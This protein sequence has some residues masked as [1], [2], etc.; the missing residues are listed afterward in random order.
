MIQ[1]KIISNNIK[2]SAISQAVV[3]IITFFLFP[4]IVSHVGKEVYGAY[5]LVMT[6]T[7]YLGVLDFGVGPA[8]VKYVAEFTGRGDNRGAK[9]IISASVSFYFVIG[10]FSAVILFALSF[11]FG[12]IFKI[13]I[14]NKEIMQQ[15]FWVAAT[16]SVFVWTGRI[17][18]GVLQGFQRYGLLAINNILFSILTGISAYIIFTNNLGI[19]LQIAY[20]IIYIIIRSNFMGRKPKDVAGSADEPKNKKNIKRRRAKKDKGTILV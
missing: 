16:A 14:A 20:G 11:F 18:D 9:K 12:Y 2:Y 15:L 3:F 1:R 5:L 7:G 4:F 8:V 13:G 10:L 19:V 17:F 6:F